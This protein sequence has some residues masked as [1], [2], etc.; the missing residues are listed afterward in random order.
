MTDIVQCSLIKAKVLVYIMTM[1]THRVL[2]F[3]ENANFLNKALSSIF[4]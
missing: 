3:H 1:Y 2:S 4:Y